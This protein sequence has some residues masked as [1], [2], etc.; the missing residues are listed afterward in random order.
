M[1]GGRLRSGRLG[2]VLAGALLT[3]ALAA[4][5]LR[6]PPA[7]PREVVAQVVGGSR[8][9]EK[10]N[11]LLITLD[12][13]R[14]DHLGCLRLSRRR[15]AQHRRAGAPRG[16]LRAG[17]LA[18]AAD[19]A[20]AHLDPDRHV[21]HVPRRARQ[22]QHGPEPVPDHDRRDALGDEATLREPSSARS[23]WTGA[24]A[25]IRA[26]TSTTT[27]STSEKYKHLDLGDV[28]RP[29]NEVV[30]AAL[31]WLEAT[32][33]GRSSRGSISTTRTLPTSPRS[34]SSRS[35]RARGLRGLYDG[36][37]AFTDQQVG[38]CL[39]WLHRQG[40]EDRTVVVVMGDHGEGL[41]SHG[42]ATH[43]YFVYD[44]A[45]HVPFL[46]ATP[47]ARAARDPGRRAGQLPWTS[48]PPSSSFSVST[49]PRGYTAARCFP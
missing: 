33:R 49:S 14:A 25:S 30:D 4:W 34:R 42:E 35:T 15:D 38:R 47:F 20:G 24:G 41:G 12:T 43:G 8:G 23:C 6:R 11:V 29:A 26:S 9:V 32:S 27:A 19:A 28:Q 44:Y 36:E 48:C 3:G 17:H 7:D 10:P 16:A 37:I 46:V 40:I 13:T 31:A 5:W 2:Y 1:K 18:R 45:L 21:P 39:S 22:R